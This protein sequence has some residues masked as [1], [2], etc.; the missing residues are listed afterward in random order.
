MRP[1]L[2]LIAAVALVLLGAAG[3]WL[4]QDGLVPVPL[5]DGAEL[6]IPAQPEFGED[7]ARVEAVLPPGDRTEAFLARQS[8]LPL[9]RSHPSG[10]WTGVLAKDLAVSRH[11]RRLRCHLRPGWRLQQGGVLDA[12]R[13]QAF[14]APM[15]E[16]MGFQTK[17]VDASTLEIR[18]RER[19]ADAPTWLSRWLIPG[20]GPFIQEGTTLTRFDGFIHGRAGLAEIRILT[21]PEL[22][23]SR[24]WADGLTSARWAWA[25]FPGQVTPE[26]M[27]RVRLAPY[28]EIRMKDGSVWFLSRRMRRLRPEVEDW[29]GTRLFGVWKGAM[30]LPYDPLGM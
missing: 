2:L 23:A 30:D 10:G 17:V 6:F 13:L 25:V 29:T 11:G 27:A 28:D 7:Q 24:A 3:W 8:A 20:T 5:A 16:K 19:S 15:A 1:R 4:Y 22:R 26:D 12:S 18:F 21:E 9:V 14:W